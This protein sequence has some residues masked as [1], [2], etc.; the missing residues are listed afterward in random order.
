[1]IFLGKEKVFKWKI[2][3]M[4]GKQNKIN[5]GVFLRQFNILFYI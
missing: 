1:M 5:I 3:E 4:L 2:F